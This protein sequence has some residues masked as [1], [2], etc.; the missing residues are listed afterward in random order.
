MTKVARIAV[1]LV[2]GLVIAAGLANADT[3]ER[4]KDGRIHLDLPVDCEMGKI[5]VVQHYVD[6]DPGPGAQDHTCGSLSY[7]GHDGIDIRTLRYAQ[8]YDGV[9]VLAAAAGVVRRTRD[10]MSDMTIRDEA[11]IT[12][13]GG[14]KAGNAVVIDHGDGWET[15]YS[16]LKR[17][18]VVVRP[19][20]RVEAGQRIGQIGLSGKTQFPHV[21]FSLRRHG[22]WVDPFTGRA[23][24]SGCG[25]P[26]NGLWSDAA[27]AALEY[28]PGGLLGGGIS[29]EVL[30]YPA[31]LELTSVPSPSSASPVM[32]AWA[33]GW[34]VREGDIWTLRLT[35]PAGT[36]LA[37]KTDTIAK[38]RPRWYRYLGRKRPAGGWPSGTY[39]ASIEIVRPAGPNA[40]VLASERRSITLP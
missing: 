40:G 22:K 24:G 14:R 28:H 20:D 6:M 39:Q 21:E 10:G 36:V 9:D 8:M 27:R 25:E 3:K 31:F 17:D 34:G 2:A 35:D 13:L 23:P 26:A 15:Q 30:D 11:A 18:S 1:L 33:V 4:P 37:E 38:H 12:A 16:H 7:D 19:G 29:G 32:I 5:C